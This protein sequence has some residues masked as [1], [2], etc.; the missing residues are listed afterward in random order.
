MLRRF[1]VIGFR[2]KERAEQVI[3]FVDTKLIA[4]KIMSLTIK[5]R[6]KLQKEP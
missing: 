4:S 3:K 6:K 1:P 5:E 2:E